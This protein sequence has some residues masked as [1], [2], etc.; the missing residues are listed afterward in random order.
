MFSYHLKFK[1]LEMPD[2]IFVDDL[3]LFFEGDHQSI[4]TMV[5]ALAVFLKEISGLHANP[6]KSY[7]YF[8]GVSRQNQEVVHII[9]AS[10]C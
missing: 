8:G 2:F 9:C 1:K 7:I 4:H 5:H 3:L 6:S 10:L